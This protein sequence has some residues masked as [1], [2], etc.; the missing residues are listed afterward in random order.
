MGSASEESCAKP[1]TPDITTKDES[2]RTLETIDSVSDPPQRNSQSVAMGLARNGVAVLLL[3]A[4]VVF[5]TTH[6][7]RGYSTRRMEQVV[8]LGDSLDQKYPSGT[9]KPGMDSTVPNSRHDYS[10]E[11]KA[12]ARHHKRVKSQN[13]PD[14]IGHATERRLMMGM[15][16]SSRSY[17]SFRSRSGSGR[18]FMP[19]PEPSASPSA[20]P[21]V[22]SSP[23]SR[24]PS[25]SPSK[26]PSVSPTLA[27]SVSKAPSQVPS[28]SPSLAPSVSFQ[29]SLSLQPSLAPSVSKE[30]SMLPSI[31]PSGE[32]TISNMPTTTPSKSPSVKPTENPTAQ[33]S[34]QPTF[35]RRTFPPT[36]APT[37]GPFGPSFGGSRSGSRSGGGGMMGMGMGGG[38]G[39]A[40]EIDDDRFDDQLED[41]LR[42][43]PADFVALFAP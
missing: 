31:S 8:D 18:T 38:R 35:V 17:G 9:S 33:P 29:P 34:I 13:H 41:L 10:R 15:G 16:G 28:H 26:H 11:Q 40:F 1:Q 27:P 42:F 2:T 30:P 6:M 5:G 3:I 24:Q 12:R 37:D 22:I 23:P 14:N 32:P 7:S 20:S 43:L 21:S 39:R 19:T 4:I 36:V 25:A